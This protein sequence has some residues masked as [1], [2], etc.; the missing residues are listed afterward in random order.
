[1]N[2]EISKDDNPGKCTRYKA[3]LA[4]LFNFIQDFA[5]TVTLIEREIKCHGLKYNSHNVVPKSNG[6]IHQHMWRSMKSVS[7]FNLGISL[8]LMLKFLLECNNK[9]YKHNHKLV[10]LLKTLP[11]P[12]QEQLNITF[13]DC[14]TAYPGCELVA[15]L[16]TKTS[17]SEDPAEPSTREPKTLE[18][19]FEYF[20]REV[21]LETKRYAYEQLKESAWCHYL[22]DLSAFIDLIDRVLG[23]VEKYIIPKD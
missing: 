15:F 21:K 23:D 16:I 4:H 22:G 7:H 19:F 14:K 12:I 13:Q 6:R 18:D 9:S 11:S 5:N 17:P 8:E 2:W 3:G 20:D 1:M 10:C